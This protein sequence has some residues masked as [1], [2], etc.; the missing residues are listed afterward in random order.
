MTTIVMPSG[1]SC[2]TRSYFLSIY[3][4]R[5]PALYSVNYHSPATQLWPEPQEDDSSKGD[6]EKCSEGASGCGIQI[7]YFFTYIP[8]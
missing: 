6:R 3:T 1:T 5:P 2:T 4:S 8:H 7:A